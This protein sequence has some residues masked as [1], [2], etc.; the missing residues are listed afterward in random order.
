VAI[1]GWLRRRID[2]IKEREAEQLRATGVHENMHGILCTK[3]LE[4]AVE[5]F[6]ARVDGRNKRSRM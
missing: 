6:A 3:L 1:V 2:R 5:E 4:R